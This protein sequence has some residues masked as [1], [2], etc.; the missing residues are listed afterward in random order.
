MSKCDEC[1][2]GIRNLV[3]QSSM[4]TYEGDKIRGRGKDY[5]SFDFCPHCGTKIENTIESQRKEL[6]K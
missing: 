3:Y 5:D 4:D 6:L 2:I 1:M